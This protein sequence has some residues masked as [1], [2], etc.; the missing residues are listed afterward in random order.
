MPNVCWHTLHFCLLMTKDIMSVCLRRSLKQFL[1]NEDQVTDPVVSPYF[2]PSFIGLPPA[3]V[4]LAELDPLR[5]D[6]LGKWN[7]QSNRRTHKMHTFIHLHS[8][9]HTHTHT[10]L[11]TCIAE[12]FMWVNI[13]YGAKDVKSTIIPPFFCHCSQ[14]MQK[15]CRKRVYRL[16]FWWF[17][18][19][20][21]SFSTCQVSHQ[22]YG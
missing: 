9:S 4:I 3:L 12:F 13:L 16:T 10:S 6:G 15:R 21:T 18:E 17:T 2:R 14:R 8:L 19:H 11:C 20:L 5:D 1:E 7:Q 22:I